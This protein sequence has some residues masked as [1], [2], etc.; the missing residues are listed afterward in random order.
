[1]R[2]DDR[3]VALVKFADSQRPCNNLELWEMSG[4]WECRTLHHG[5]VGNRTPRPPGSGPNCLGF[6][7][8]GRL[9]ATGSLDGTRLWDLA[10][11]TEVGHLP[12]SGGTASLLFL[13]D[14]NSLYTQGPGGL[15]R[16]PL[17]RQTQRTKAPPEDISLLQVG[18]AQTL[19]VPGITGGP[20]GICCDRKGRWLAAVDSS[21][22]R[23]ILVDLD[24]PASKLI[25]P[26]PRVAGCA[27]TPDG[28]WA[29]TWTVP[30]TWPPPP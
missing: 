15:H 4:G 21:H 26:H 10:T 2:R 1:I 27:L 12:T 30:L 20:G 11:F 6:S 22:G 23:A 24:N 18:P 19:D 17:R 7:P 28:R 14:G 3:Q 9:L 8:D 25:L 29:V 16:W 13:P 5:L